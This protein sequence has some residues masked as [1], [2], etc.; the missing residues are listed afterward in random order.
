MPLNSTRGAGSAKG[1]GFGAGGNSFILATGGTET[2]CGDFKIHTFTGP[3]T[4]C[5]SAVG[6]PA[7]S[8]TVDYLVVA[9]GEVVEQQ[10]HVVKEVMEVVEQVVLENLLVL[11]LGVI[12]LLL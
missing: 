10:D 6:N 11:L 2:T 7:G 8:T 5:V 1:F 3:G 9:G 4:F 12:Q